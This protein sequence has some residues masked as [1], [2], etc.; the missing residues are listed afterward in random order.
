MG[1]LLEVTLW[2]IKQGWSFSQLLVLAFYYELLSWW[3]LMHHF[4]SELWDSPFLLTTK[5][6]SDASLASKLLAF[7]SILHPSVIVLDRTSLHVTSNASWRIQEFT[8]TQT[9]E[10][11]LSHLRGDTNTH[12]Y[13]LTRVVWCL[14]S[15]VW[16]A[17]WQTVSCKMGFHHVWS[18]GL[19]L[20][21]CFILS[22][23]LARRWS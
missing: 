11:P 7:L 19:S 14:V 23:C 16:E 12:K 9:E 6:P 8:R 18:T 13:S 4:S 20:R 21:V 2:L 17:S 22:F 3:D 5:S 15:S 10:D 1:C